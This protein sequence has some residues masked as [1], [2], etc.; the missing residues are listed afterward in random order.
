MDMEHEIKKAS[1][2]AQ[3]AAGSIDTDEHA[4]TQLAGGVHFIQHASNK[5]CREWTEVKADH[6]Q[7]FVDAGFITRTLYAAPIS[8][9]LHD[10]VFDCPDDPHCPEQADS[11]SAAPS[12]AAMTTDQAGFET[13][14]KLHGGLNL[15]KDISNERGDY[16]PATYWSAQTEIAWRAWANK[17]LSDPAPTGESL[18]E[19][20]DVFGNVEHYLQRNGQDQL[21]AV[22]KHHVA[23]LASGSSAAK[24][25]V[26]LHEYVSDRPFTEGKKF[27]EMTILDRSQCVDGME[28][29]AS[30]ATPRQPEDGSGLS[31]LNREAFTSDMAFE[32]HNADLA[33]MKFKYEELLAANLPIDV[34]TLSNFIRSI[35]GDHSMGA[36]SL[37]EA[38]CGRYAPTFAPKGTAVQGGV[39]D[40]DAIDSALHDAMA[41]QLGDLYYCGRVWSAWQVGTMT[42]NDFG[43]AS[44]DDDIVY[45][46]VSAAREAFKAMLAASPAPT[47]VSK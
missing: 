13:W 38:I 45:N 40:D 46:F 41:E 14:A 42:E 18:S 7:T 24:P 5:A 17:P 6:L 10:I 34:D 35:D 22:L 33:A 12:D 43:I 21:A 2:S 27:F 28:L 4:A 30:L 23:A 3:Q 1:P 25:V 8:K 16:F 36:G 39:P 19:L 37:A 31:M 26:R 29:Y 15:E 44:E 47:G 11:S 9:S 32:C 20:H